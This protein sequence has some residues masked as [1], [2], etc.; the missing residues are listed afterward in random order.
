MK[1]I[2]LILMMMITTLFSSA[3][4]YTIIGKGLNGEVPS[5]GS[6][7]YTQNDNYSELK[8]YI[9][10]LVQKSFTLCNMRII[11]DYSLKYE[12][13]QDKG[14]F[15]IVRQDSSNPNVFYFEIPN[16]YEG[17]SGTIQYK[18]TLGNIEHKGNPVGN[19]NADQAKH[20]AQAMASL[21]GDSTTPNNQVIKIDNSG[22]GFINIIWT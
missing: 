20:K 12:V 16:F 11:D 4:T 2:A 13:F 6:I 9:S 8:V 19:Q 22:G 18:T 14:K 7:S 3:K 1:R 17:Q 5:K 10:D 21:F 15:V